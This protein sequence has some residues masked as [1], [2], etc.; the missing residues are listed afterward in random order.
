MKKILILISLFTAIMFCAHSQNTIAV[1]NGGEPTFYSLL[2]SAFA[3]AQSGDTI[4]VPG[5][6][7][8]LGT[9]NIDKEIHV[10][11][12]GHNPDSTTATGIT[13]LEGLFILNDGA[14][15]SS[16]TGFNLGGAVITGTSGLNDDVDNIS[17]SRCKT[18]TIALS[19]LSTNWK[20]TENVIGSDLYGGYESSI[21]E[22]V[23]NNYIANNIIQGSTYGF[24]PNTT[25]SNNIFLNDGTYLIISD[26]ESCLISN[27]VFLNIGTTIYDILNCTFN[28]NLFVTSFTLPGGCIGFN[29]IANQSPSSIFINQSGDAFS[30]THDYHLQSSSPGNNA[31][32]DGTDI[33]IYGGAFSWKEGSIP[34]NPHIQSKVINSLTDLSGNLLLNIKV[35]AQDY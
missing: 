23:H 24:G 35:E 30:Y 2:S 16:F 4:Y 34:Y 8:T 3:N 29:N 26:I 11:G 15:N 12:T 18:G 32:T 21:D 5:F 1:Q 27:N 31:G 19:R 17:I 6:A 22:G 10:I 7:Y 9:L 28:N 14:D 25:I 20:I 33:G 13:Y